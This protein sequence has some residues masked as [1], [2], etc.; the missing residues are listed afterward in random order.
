MSVVSAVISNKQV[1]TQFTV[2]IYMRNSG[3]VS[4]AFIERMGHDD[5]MI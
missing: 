3:G 5:M 4:V 1:C 2:C